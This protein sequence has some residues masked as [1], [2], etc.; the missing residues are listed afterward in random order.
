MAG[1][2]AAAVLERPSTWITVAGTF[3]LPA[4][5]VF[6]KLRD[7]WDKLAILIGGYISTGLWDIVEEAAAAAGGATAV[8]TPRSTPS[9]TP[10]AAPVRAASPSV[11]K[12]T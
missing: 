9:Y 5:A 7:P 11:G 2:Q 3:G 6:G 10:P 12:Y 4:L 8:Y 1:K